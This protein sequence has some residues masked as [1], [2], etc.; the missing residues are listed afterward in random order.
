MSNEA[1]EINAFR[2]HTKWQHSRD[3]NVTNL[4]KGCD[5]Q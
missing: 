3:T 5:I 4:I 2:F 1:A